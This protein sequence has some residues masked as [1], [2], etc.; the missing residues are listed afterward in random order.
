MI[1]LPDGSLQSILDT[2]CLIQQIAA[3]T[4]FESKRAEIVRDLFQTQGLADVNID[5][6]GNVLAR[7]PGKTGERPVVL[8]AH[9]DTVFPAGFPLMLD[10]QPERITGPGI[11]DNALGLAVLL[12]IVPLLKA[13]R[14]SLPGDLWLAATVCEEGLGNL[15][16]IQAVTERFADRPLAY[17]FLEGMG[18]GN[19]LHRGLGVERYRVRIRTAGGHSWVDH[20]CPS[21]VHEL[22]GLADKLVALQLP[23]RPRTTLNIGVIEGGTSVNT[24]AAEAFL[25]LDLRS[26]GARNLNELAEKT[27]QTA[28]S[29]KKK[30]V[31][32]EVERIGW[33]PAGEIPA[34]HALVRLSQQVLNS[35]GVSS[36]PDIASTDANLPLSLGYPAVTLGVTTGD[37]AHTA[38]EYIYTKPVEKG[39]K[40]VVEMVVRVWNFL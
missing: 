11:G 5:P 26:E 34:D 21:A 29:I 14:V 10:R 18:L 13:A 38:Q 2:A 27:L 39:L 12:E 16:G 31:D 35:L 36:H 6:T 4:F 40:Q 17:I 20:G 19:I 25:E 37:R 22:A 15:R 23:R 7:W 8:S 30:G 32:V 3:P 28:Q 9:M 33:R 24:I 1:N